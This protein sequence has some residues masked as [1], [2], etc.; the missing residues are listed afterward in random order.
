MWYFPF[1]SKVGFILSQTGYPQSP[2]SD[3]SWTASWSRRYI[4]ERANLKWPNHNLLN[5]G[6]H[7]L[8]SWCSCSCLHPIRWQI[9]CLLEAEDRGC[10]LALCNKGLI[11]FAVSFIY[12]LSPGK[13]LD[14]GYWQIEARTPAWFEDSS[15]VQPTSRHFLQKTSS[16]STH[17]ESFHAFPPH[18]FWAFCPCFLWRS[19]WKFCCKV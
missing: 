11:C 19:F 1:F 16:S 5:I 18:L 12:L 3:L 17:S 7:S 15:T 2:V 6:E 13:I 8:V 9:S 14:S 10:S 4:K